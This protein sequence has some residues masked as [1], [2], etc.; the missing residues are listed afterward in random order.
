[1]TESGLNEFDIPLVASN[2]TTTLAPQPVF[3][4]D[5]LL[6]AQIELL[7]AAPLVLPVADALGIEVDA[8]AIQAASSLSEQEVE[9]A[10]LSVVDSIEDK[11]ELVS[12]HTVREY[13]IREGVA[14]ETGR[15]V[16]HHYLP[17]GGGS[18]IKNPG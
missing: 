6:T 16:I 4:A 1:M 14:V 17:A 5:D 11:M 7:K 18:I 2:T 3:S 9:N 15:K 10:A 8:E 12:E 13:G